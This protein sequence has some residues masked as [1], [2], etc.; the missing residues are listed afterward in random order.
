MSKQIVTLTIGEKEYSFEMTMEAY[1]SYIN[2]M[3]PNN[4]VS[5]SHNF[6]VKTVVEADK[7]DVL[8]LLEQP[9][10]A[11]QIAGALTAEYAPDLGIEIK[12]PSSSAK[13]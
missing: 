1:N 3:M 12:K 7:K 8:E 9:G 4:K 11:G 2:G 5:P 6:V 10:A 13:S